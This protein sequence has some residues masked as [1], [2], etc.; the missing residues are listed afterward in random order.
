MIHERLRP[1][2][3]LPLIPLLLTANPGPD[4][5]AP[6]GKP[7]C[8]AGPV[9]VLE[10]TGPVMQVQLDG[11]GSSAG[12]GGALHYLWVPCGN[13]AVT[14]SDPTDPTPVLT[15][16]M[17]RT[18]VLECHIELKVSNSAGQSA[19]STAV[20]IRDT[21]PPA[22]FCPPDVTVEL[23]DPTDPSF[24]GVAT[25]TD[26]HS[27]NPFVSWS[28]DVSGISGAGLGTIVRTWSASDGCFTS[29]CAQQIK[30]ALT[31]HFDIYPNRC[32]NELVLGPDAT[33]GETRVSASVLGNAIDVTTV[34]L[35]S[36]QFVGGGSFDTGAVLTPVLVG[37][38]DVGQPQSGLEFCDCSLIDPDGKTDIYM[39]FDKQALIQTFGLQGMPS[40]TE[41]PFQ[42]QGEFQNNDPFQGQDCILIRLK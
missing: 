32:P 6:A 37:Y 13:P 4:P 31:V 19:C 39:E 38:A 16:D 22:I 25:A 29:V 30:V 5:S 33:D 21:T 1:L 3:V 27:R 40:G 42:I 9:Q 11:T 26:A 7:L 10:C 18:C 14:I 20:V 36:L 34:D 17:T 24:T 12:G 2:S 41:L 8:D 28:D 15:V 23:G 35:G